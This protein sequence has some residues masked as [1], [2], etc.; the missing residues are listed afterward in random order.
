M[1]P[2]A[3]AQ[4]PLATLALAAVF[5]LLFQL[6]AWAETRREAS[7]R[8]RALTTR[9]DTY[10]TAAH[11]LFVSLNALVLDEMREVLAAKG[12]AAAPGPV[13]RHRTFRDITRRLLQLFVPPAPQAP[14]ASQ[15]D[16]HGDY[17]VSKRTFDPEDFVKDFDLFRPDR[18]G[19][20]YLLLSEH[21]AIEDM[22]AKANTENGSPPKDPD[23][24]LGTLQAAHLI[25]LRG[26]LVGKAL[27]DAPLRKALA[28]T[29]KANAEATPARQLRE[30]LALANLHGGDKGGWGTIHMPQDD[31]GTHRLVPVKP[32]DLTDPIAERFGPGAL[33]AM[34]LPPHRVPPAAWYLVPA[35]PIALLAL[36]VA[37][38]AD[39]RRA[40]FTEDYS[41]T[42]KETRPAGTIE[43][44]CTY[45]S[46]TLP[47]G[48]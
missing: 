19:L 37:L 23:A 4:L 46:P 11:Q 26:A 41:C 48:G 6:I 17:V 28:R 21:T 36:A 45:R 40:V 27:I 25:C 14:K 35:V 10:A 29:V 22:I 7:A 8:R 9:F 12:T 32:G 33:Q 18:A 34:R 5:Y 24:L 47:G 13:P 20:V 38:N 42:I 30:I 1:D 15:A 39:L 2:L 43:E 31:N 3:L 16:S 44:T